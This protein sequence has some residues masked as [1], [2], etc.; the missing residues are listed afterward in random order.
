MTTEQNPYCKDT[1]INALHLELEKLRTQV[2]QSE[3]AVI[4]LRR[5]S[6][7]QEAQN[8]MLGI[9]LLPISL[10]EQLHKILQL[11]LNIPWLSLEKKGCF[12]LS[13][14]IQNTL[15]MVAQYNLSEELLK[16]CSTVLY[17]DCL[18]GKAAKYNHLIFK[19]CMDADHEYLTEKTMPHG[20]YIL[21]IIS[22]GK[23]LGVLNLYVK[24]GH[25][26]D[27]LEQDFLYS[28]AR[29]LAGIIER[30]M[31]EQKLHRLSYHDDLTGLANRRHFM[32]HLAQTVN[33]NQRVGRCFAVLFLDLDYF[34]EA[35]DLYGHDYGDEVL[36]EVA[37]RIENSI[38]QTDLIARL[39]GDEFIACISLLNDPKYAVSVAEKIQ[40]IVSQPYYIKDAII[41]IG[42]SIGISIYPQHGTD[43]EILLKK[44]DIALY[45]AKGQR[46]SITMYQGE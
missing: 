5:R 37:R 44:A 41:K 35:N 4:E 29:L 12:F 28:S 39:G 19:S 34:K 20:H 11:I 24:H 23:T 25:C 9:S 1:E 26:S 40:R 6:D 27:K 8:Q 36:V 45:S 15:T 13:N 16:Q 2:H 14:E 18:C 33:I 10:K 38:R 46:G 22:S 3:Q 21:P 30:K 31:L 7:I 43:A 42:V 17:G 32:E